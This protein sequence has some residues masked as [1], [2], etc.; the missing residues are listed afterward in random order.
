MGLA[1]PIH[2]YGQLW[3]LWIG[4]FPHQPGSCSVGQLVGRFDASLEVESSQPSADLRLGSPAQL[5]SIFLQELFIHPAV[6][7]TGLPK[8][9]IGSTSIILFGVYIYIYK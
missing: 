6:T 7:N 8:W 3:Q 5:G 9:V 1:G 2:S 4:S